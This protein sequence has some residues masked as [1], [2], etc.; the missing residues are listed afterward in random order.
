MDDLKTLRQTVR[1]RRRAVQGSTR[2]A[3]SEAA[4]AH[5]LHYPPLQEALRLAI[6]LALPE[7][8]DTAPLIEALWAAGKALY[9]P[10]VRHKNEA[11]CWLPYR[12]ET[13]LQPDVLGIAA[14]PYSPQEALAAADLD[15][16][17]M[18]LVAWNKQ[19]QR[20][21]M[22]GGY[23]DRSLAQAGAF[24]LG[25]AYACQEALFTAQPWDLPL[26]ALASEAGLLIF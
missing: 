21:G 24:R 23:Y 13:R 14:P 19:G 4:A 5:A 15:G 11:L 26:H 17:I 20:L 12:P 7:E 3:Y 16:V 8:I 2:Q 10:Y 6:F 1:A 18:P 9:L 25:Y 22:G